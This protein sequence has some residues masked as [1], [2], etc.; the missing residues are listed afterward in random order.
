MSTFAF[1]SL[2]GI[3]EIV[4]C[5]DIGDYAKTVLRPMGLRDAAAPEDPPRLRVKYR[6][7]AYTDD[8]YGGYPLFKEVAEPDWS[9]ARIALLELKGLATA[10]KALSSIHHVGVSPDDVLALCEKGLHE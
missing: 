7:Y 6:T 9:N 2:D 10:L 5:P 1:E 3:R 4:F 8:F